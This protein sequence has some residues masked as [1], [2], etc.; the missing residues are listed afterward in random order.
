MMVRSFLNA[1]QIVRGGNLREAGLFNQCRA[2]AVAKPSRAAEPDITCLPIGHC[3]A[4]P[5]CIQATVQRFSQ[6]VQIDACGL[7]GARLGEPRLIHM[8]HAEKQVNLLLGRFSRECVHACDERGD[9]D[10]A[11]DPNLTGFVAFECELTV[12][13]SNVTACPVFN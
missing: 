12:R 11:S 1:F 13:P 4:Q 8:G 2:Q 9:A 5:I 7:H 10:A 3:S 6:D